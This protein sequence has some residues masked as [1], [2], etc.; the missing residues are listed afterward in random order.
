MAITKDSTLIRLIHGKYGQ[1]VNHNP[2]EIS[3]GINTLVN[4]EYSF[5][6]RLNFSRK[7]QVDMISDIIGR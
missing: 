6:D 5:E 4:A 1:C 3:E 2:D 7:H